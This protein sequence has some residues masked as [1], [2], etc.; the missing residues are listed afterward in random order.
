MGEVSPFIG[1]TSVG[2]RQAFELHRSFLQ[3]LKKSPNGKLHGAQK[4][5]SFTDRIRFQINTSPTLS[6]AYPG[7]NMATATLQTTY[8]KW[9][10]E[11]LPPTPLFSPQRIPACQPWVRFTG[12]SHRYQPC[13]RFLRMAALPQECVMAGESRCSSAYGEGA[14]M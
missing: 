9:H 2:E 8:E 3:V 4:L 6:L 14:K 12:G 10:F 5:V 1:A 13:C 11:G 7:T